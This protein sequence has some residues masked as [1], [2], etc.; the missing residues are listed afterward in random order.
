[1]LERHPAD[2][3]RMRNRSAWPIF[4][5]SCENSLSVYLLA[6]VNEQLKVLTYTRFL[7]ASQN[8]DNNGI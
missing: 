5:A 6:K 1:M 2:I 4:L 3:F 7:A 8:Y